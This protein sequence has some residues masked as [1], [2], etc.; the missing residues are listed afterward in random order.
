MILDF[1]VYVECFSE[2]FTVQ[3]KVWCCEWYGK[4][5]GVVIT[6]MD[7]SDNS[8]ISLDIFNVSNVCILHP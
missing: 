1:M 8:I 7:G 5:H 3:E 2:W 4:L 6:P